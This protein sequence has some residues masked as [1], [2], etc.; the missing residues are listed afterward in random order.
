MRQHV[1]PTLLF[2]HLVAI[3]DNGA[4]DLTEGDNHFEAVARSHHVA[5][6][7]KGI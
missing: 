2:K 3:V 4:A 5:S 1:K 6:F 7:A